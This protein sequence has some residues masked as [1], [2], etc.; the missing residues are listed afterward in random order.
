MREVLNTG[1]GWISM[2]RVELLASETVEG[3]DAVTVRELHTA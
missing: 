1:G 2:I 3:E